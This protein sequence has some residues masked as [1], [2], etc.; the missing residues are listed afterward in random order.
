MN[1]V[2]VEYFSVMIHYILKTLYQQQR[3]PTIL[4]MSGKC[5]V[6]TLKEKLHQVSGQSRVIFS[7]RGHKN[8][9]VIGNNTHP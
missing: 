5:F 9:T 4:R 7:F 1:R 2:Q 6:I 3:P 8:S